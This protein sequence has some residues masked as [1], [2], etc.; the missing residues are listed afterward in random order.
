VNQLRHPDDAVIGVEGRRRLAEGAGTVRMENR[1][2]H[3]DGSYRWIYWALTAEQGLIYVIGRNITADKEAAQAHRRTEEQLHQLQKMDSVGQLTGGIAHDFNNLL[4]VILG[5]LETLERVVQTPSARVIKAIR[6]AID[7][8]TRAVTL[9]QRLLA[10]AQRQP[11]RPRG[12]DL[13][14]LVTSMRDL[15]YRT[16]G[17]VIEYEFALDHARP[18]C[19]CDA[20]QLETALL[21]LVI[22]A[23][24]AMENGG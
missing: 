16:H 6:S 1:F 2:R 21:N 10:Y 8:A 11:L 19:F 9:I 3:K 23:R 20:N 22:N 13:N 5:N 14:E 18:F 7:G 4:T 24:D 17:E 15:I 12:V